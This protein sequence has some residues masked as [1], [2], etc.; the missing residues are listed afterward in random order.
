MT[1]GVI[2]GMSAGKAICV[3]AINVE[4]RNADITSCDT[5]TLTN[6][7][8]VLVRYGSKTLQKR[9]HP[10]EWKVTGY[11]FYVCCC[12]LLGKMLIKI[13][14]YG[15]DLNLRKELRYLVLGKE[16]K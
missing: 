6:Y 9:R 8:I 3:D 11:R 16:G 7:T 12:K 2:L 14:S 13:I 10:K 4:L 5:H 15:V 1:K